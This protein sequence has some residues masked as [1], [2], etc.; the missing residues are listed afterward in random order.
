MKLGTNFHVVLRLRICVRASTWGTVHCHNPSDRTMVLGST[1]A[2][3]E[4][5]IKKFSVGG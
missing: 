2:L 1:Q 4:M 5:S 3:S